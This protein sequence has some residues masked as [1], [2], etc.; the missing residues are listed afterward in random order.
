MSRVVPENEP[1]ARQPRVLLVED[2][3]PTADGLVRLLG[4]D[5]F[6]VKACHTGR[7]ALAAAAEPDRWAAA[8]V[9]VHLPDWNGLVLAGELRRAL[10]GPVPIIAVSGDTSMSVLNSLTAVGVNHFVAKPVNPAALAKLL[11]ELTDGL[12]VGGGV[13]SL[14]PE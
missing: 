5:G 4:R 11:R 3:G 9:D 2:H 12:A 7:D 8:V 10:P 14:G 13:A 6:A 1:P